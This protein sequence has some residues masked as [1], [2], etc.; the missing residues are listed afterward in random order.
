MT[1]KK[2]PKN[3]RK[4]YKDTF[5]FP[6]NFL[7][8]CN[9]LNVYKY[10]QFAILWIIS[11]INKQKSKNMYV[12]VS[13]HK[14][15]FLKMVFLILFYN[16]FWS[17]KCG[18]YKIF[19]LLLHHGQGGGHQEDPPQVPQPEVFT[20]FWR[21]QKCY[22]WT[23]LWS[24]EDFFLAALSSSRSLVVHWSVGPL[25]VGHSCE[26]WPLECWRV[27]KTYLPTYLWDSSDICDSCDSSDSNDSSN[28]KL[29]D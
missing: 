12:R 8:C 19:G 13:H 27:I 16:T 10:I 1:K 28:K 7:E 4:L 20:M 21:A 26:K 15:K 14:Y 2:L 29:C 6:K 18:E 24:P 23:Y 11:K 3:N 17:I 22:F 25:S 9:K 5:C